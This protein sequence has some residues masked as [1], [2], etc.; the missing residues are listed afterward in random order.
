[1]PSTLKHHVQKS[2]G[3]LGVYERA[4]A[5]WIYDFYWILADRQ[6]IDDR[7]SELAFYRDLL[8]G[9][10]RGDV[11]FDVGANQGY[12]TDIFLRLGAK[13]VALEP[14]ELSQEVLRQKFLK[15]RLRKKPLVVVGKAVSDRSSVE[16]FWIDQPGS[17]KNTLSQK[18]AG[19]LRDDGKRFGHKLG[20]E[21]QREVETLTLW[22]LIA[23]YGSPF[24]VKIDV[25]GYELSVLR[26]LQ[27]PV[28]YLSFE[29][30][31]PEFRSEGLECV[32]VLA[33]LARDGEFNYASDCRHGL[34]LGRWTKAQEFS[35][36]LNSCRA[37]S[38]EVFWKTQ[39]EHT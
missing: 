25:E 5:S 3:E 21:Y 31:L 7:S 8:K 13:V 28:P 2:L 23:E 14:D 12:K 33:R 38:I 17:A 27:R 9:F 26:G 16:T 32:Q 6:I 24:F 37:A 1:M 30:N 11:V 4:K 29:V 18:W 15:C 19:T 35:A 10:R 36:I 22:D 34:A 20:F 39:V